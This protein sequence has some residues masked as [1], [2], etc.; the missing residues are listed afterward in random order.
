M[1]RRSAGLLLYR[2]VEGTLEVLLVHPGGPHWA[3]RDDGAWSLPKGEYEA[4]EAP[5]D[6]AKR[7]FGE[8]LGV[9]APSDRSPTFLGERPQASGKRVKAWALQGDLNV[10]TV[11]SNTF[12]MEWPPGS[13]GTRE[14]PEV[15][16][17]EW[18]GLDAAKGKLVPGQVQFID[19]LSELL[20]EGAT[21]APRTQHGHPVAG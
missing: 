3:K 7:E 17:S 6:V 2:W 15:D 11:H 19:R 4:E 1:P 9:N 16:R 18:F 5:L 20:Q 10:E 13:G 8:E 21:S 14:F 12:A